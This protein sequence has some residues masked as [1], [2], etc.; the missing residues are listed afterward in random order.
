MRLDNERP[1]SNVEDRRGRGGGFQFPG[2]GGGRRVKSDGRS[3]W[4]LQPVHLYHAGDSPI[5]R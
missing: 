3:W 5:S 1:S 4:R 2:G